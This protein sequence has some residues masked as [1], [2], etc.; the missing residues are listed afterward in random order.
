MFESAP[1]GMAMASATDLTLLDV[2]GALCRMLGATREML[3]GRSVLDITHPD[4]RVLDET[5]MDEI[6]GGHTPALVSGGPTSTTSTPGCSSAASSAPSTTL[7]GARSPPSRSRA[8]R[9]GGSGLGSAER[10]E[11]RP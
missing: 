10:C 7:P 3:I 1:T 2:N 4:D 9:T 5:Q 8:M 6:I 11:V